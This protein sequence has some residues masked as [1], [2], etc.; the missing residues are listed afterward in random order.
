MWFT[1]EPNSPDPGGRDAGSQG[2]W[3]AGIRK[4]PPGPRL[5]GTGC[6]AGL[7][8]FPGHLGAHPGTVHPRT[9][10]ASE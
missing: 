2:A 8:P 6:P 5:L 4:R 1:H 9:S 3:E 10:L 7:S